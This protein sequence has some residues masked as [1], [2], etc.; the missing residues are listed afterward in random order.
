MTLTPSTL[1]SQRPNC[2][3]GMGKK[4]P[5]AG[6]GQVGTLGFFIWESLPPEQ[7]EAWGSEGQRGFTVR[8]RLSFSSE[9]WAVVMISE[10]PLRGDCGG[11]VLA[12]GVDGS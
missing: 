3:L 11:P 12:A 9:G 6:L 4:S 8:L 2:V 5:R 10:W 1:C 7:Q